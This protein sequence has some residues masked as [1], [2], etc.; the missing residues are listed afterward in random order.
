VMAVLVSMAG[1]RAILDKLPAEKTWKPDGSS[2]P[3]MLLDGWQNPIIFV[4]T[5]GMAWV[6]SSGVIVRMV[7]GA[8]VFAT[9]GET[10]RQGFGGFFAS[11]GPDGDF[12]TGD[13]N[14]YSFGN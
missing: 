8:G 1:N 9:N 14:V 12:S 7:T 5:G 4:P 11:A 2:G 10:V 3:P 13:D 6:N